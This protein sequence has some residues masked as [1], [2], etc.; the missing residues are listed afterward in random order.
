M[1]LQVLVASESLVA[2]G[3]VALAH[4]TSHNTNAVLLVTR[5]AL[6]ADLGT[7]QLIGLPLDLV[8]HHLAV[9]TEAVGRGRRALQ[10]VAANGRL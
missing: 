2:S 1:S 8:H 5:L 9:G 4:G 3:V 6:R 7:L 10:V